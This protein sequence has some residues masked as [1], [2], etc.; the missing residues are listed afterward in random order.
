M[1]TDGRF[2]EQAVVLGNRR[3]YEGMSWRLRLLRLTPEGYSPTSQ[4]TARAATGIEEIFELP[5]RADVVWWPPPPT[6][7][8]LPVI[9][10]GVS[11]S[12]YFPS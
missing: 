1:G 10:A 4:A 9:G 2:G 12:V 8:D 7:Y 5:R 11:D 6:R 3:S